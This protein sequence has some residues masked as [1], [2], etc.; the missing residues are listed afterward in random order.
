MDLAAT[1]DFITKTDPIY[2]FSIPPPLLFLVPL[3]CQWQKAIPMSW[4][5]HDLQ[6]PQKSQ[7]WMKICTC[8]SHRLLER[9]KGSSVLTPLVFAFSFFTSPLTPSSDRLT[10]VTKK[11]LDSI[12]S[13]NNRRRLLLCP[14]R[15]CTHSPGYHLSTQEPVFHQSFVSY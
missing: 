15:P 12:P 13:S 11:T 1:P 6:P 9:T 14:S 10:S 7:R 5:R 2:P 4:A 8:N 3:L